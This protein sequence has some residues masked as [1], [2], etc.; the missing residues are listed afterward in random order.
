MVD[1]VSQYTSIKKDIDHGIQAVIDSSRFINGPAVSQ[2]TDHLST[3]L[4]CHHSLGCGNG[5]DAIQIALMALGLEPGDEVITTPFTFVAT[6]EVISLLKLKPV[7]VDIDPDTFNLDVSKIQAAISPKTKVILPVHLFGQS[8]DMSRIM[9]I[10]EEHN[11]YVI[12]DNAQS[13]GCDVSYQGQMQKTGTIGHFGTL[14]FFPSKNLGCYGDG[15]ALSSTDETLFNKATM[16]AKHGS[17]V[18]YYYDAVGINSRLDAMQAAILDVK[19][20]HLNTYISRRREAADHYDAMLSDMDGL[21]LPKR[22]SYSSHVF[23]QYTMR[24]LDRRDELK[25]HLKTQGIPSMVYY[26]KPL[27]L[28]PAY[29]YLGYSQ[30]DFPLSEQYGEEVLS[31]PMHTELDAEQLSFITDSIKSFFQ[32]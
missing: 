13:I 28:Q 15:G 25:D 5:T 16:I 27:H 8:A 9:E 10:A 24:V 20:R 29:E 21:I 4:G 30:G 6:V 18:K 19:L 32:K 31:I 2:F 17:K 12:E 23:H 11:L 22:A 3:Y 1:L 26:P 14:S 7:F